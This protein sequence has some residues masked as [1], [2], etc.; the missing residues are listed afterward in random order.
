M[1]R[2]WPPS[3]PR[4]QS[5]LPWGFSPLRKP[6]LSVLCC[7]CVH[8]SSDLPAPDFASVTLADGGIERDLDLRIPRG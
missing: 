1:P 5:P 6:R 8:P 4:L 3:H 7:F 2:A